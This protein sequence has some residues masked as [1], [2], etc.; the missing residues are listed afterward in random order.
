[1]ESGFCNA[2]LVASVSK[3]GTEKYVCDSNIYEDC[4]FVLLLGNN[5]SAARIL[6]LRYYKLHTEDDIYE[7]LLFTIILVIYYIYPNL[8]Y[9]KKN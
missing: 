6:I 1:M 7:F 4:S 5:A 3:A 9:N 2:L 8:I